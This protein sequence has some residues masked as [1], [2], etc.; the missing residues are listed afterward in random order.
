MQ[1]LLYFLAQS[2]LYRNNPIRLFIFK[3]F[4]FNSHLSF[5]TL[6]SEDFLDE[7]RFFFVKNVLLIEHF[8]LHVL[9]VKDPET[10][11]E[12]EEMQVE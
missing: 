2:C 12:M 10:K 4:F 1:I 9:V 11:K 5:S 3:V 8:E 7:W 6:I